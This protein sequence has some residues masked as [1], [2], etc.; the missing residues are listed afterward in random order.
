MGNGRTS[1]KKVIV[2]I[3]VAL[4]AVLA[5]GGAAYGVWVIVSNQSKQ[6]DTP[7][8][9]T[10]SVTQRQ[11][12]LSEKISVITQTQGAKKAQEQVDKEI[13]ASNDNADKSYLYIMKA[14]LEAYKSEFDFEA[15]LG[16]AQ[17]AEDLNPTIETA[18]T[19]AD[20]AYHL[21]QKELALKYYR[22]YL[23]R[24]VLP[25]GTILDPEGRSSY[26]GLVTEIEAEL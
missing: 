9:S 26:E 18:I 2:I 14:G 8:E 19:I 25:D 21:G 3:I 12:E 20:T 10:Q 15:V 6:A 7:T 4:F 22:L 23:E 5:V 24:T 1:R 17:Q 16:Y 13:S 11:Q